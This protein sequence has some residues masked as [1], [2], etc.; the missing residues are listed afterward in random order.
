[1]NAIVNAK[2]VGECHASADSFAAPHILRSARLRPRGR[3]LRY[4]NGRLPRSGPRSDRSEFLVLCDCSSCASHE[5]RGALRARSRF[6]TL[7]GSHHFV[8]SFRLE[9]NRISGPSIH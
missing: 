6:R 2:C 8:Q 7:S 9:P 1:M 4:N 5:F 3:S